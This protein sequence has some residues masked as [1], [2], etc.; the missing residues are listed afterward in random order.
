LVSFE[1]FS[2]GSTSDGSSEGDSDGAGPKDAG[3]ETAPPLEDDGALV[4]IPAGDS[5]PIGP[6]TVHRVLET[7]T[8]RGIAVTSEHL[9]WVE[10]H[11]ASTGTGSW[12]VY[13]VSKQNADGPADEIAQAT[14]AFD[15]AVSDGAYAYFTG[16][17][18][19]QRVML[20]DA[21][22]P[23][24]YFPAGVSLTYLTADAYGRVYASG[25]NLIVMGPC[26]SP[27]SC[28]TTGPVS[29]GSTSIIPFPPNP[30]VFGASGIAV[31]SKLLFWGHTDGPGVSRADLSISTL[32]IPIKEMD[33]EMPPPPEPV[34]G[35]AADESNVYWIA[36]NHA[37]LATA[38]TGEP[39]GPRLVCDGAA[40]LGLDAG[41]GDNADLA[42]DSDWIY[43]TA[44][45][46]GLIRKCSKR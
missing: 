39:R 23:S 4:D 16:S 14:D 26:S 11:V 33:F 8:L 19:V 27:S 10:G 44:P 9:Y 3:L 37:I 38:T 21:S 35:V 31:Q 34:S 45:A 7:Q 22:A 15:V 20:G 42:V 43:F 24:E 25:P 6:F 2:G 28:T 41:F 12:S 36:G 40:D 1:G 17:F 29:T 30:G 5:A 13:R 46:A 32:P 18:G